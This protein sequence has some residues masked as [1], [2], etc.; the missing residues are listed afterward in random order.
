[1]GYL[2]GADVQRRSQR[3]ASSASWVPAPGVPR[4]RFISNSSSIMCSRSRSRGCRWLVGESSRARWRGA[5]TATAAARLP[6]TGADNGRAARAADSVEDQ[7]GA[8]HGVR[9]AASS[10]GSITFS[11]A[12]NAGRSWNTGRRSRHLA[13]Q[14]ADILV[15]AKR[16]S[17]RSRRVPCWNVQPASNPRKWTCPPEAPGWRPPRRRRSRRSHSCEVRT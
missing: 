9:P 11:I 12:V 8:R 1:M 10:S 5:R 13:A 15:H 17:R 6:T 2:A 14:R 3:L 16:S 4:S 7:A